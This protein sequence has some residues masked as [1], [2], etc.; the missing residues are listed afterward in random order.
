MQGIGSF[1]TLPF[2][3]MAAGV[4]FFQINDGQARIVLERFQVLVAKEIFD[5]PEVGAAPDEFRGAGAP[6][7]GKGAVDRT[8]GQDRT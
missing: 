6:K 1:S 3:G 7:S 5:V 2:T 8:V 4:R